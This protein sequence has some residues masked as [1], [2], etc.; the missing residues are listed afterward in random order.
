MRQSSGGCPCVCGSRLTTTC[1]QPPA[2]QLP[3]ARVLCRQVGASWRAVSLGGAGG[4][5]PLPVG[6]AAE[7][8]DQQVESDEVLAQL[9][10][11]VEEGVPAARQRWR[12]ACYQAARLAAE[13]GAAGGA[14]GRG[15]DGLCTH[16]LHVVRLA[17]SSRC[18]RTQ[19]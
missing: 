11:E 15:A 8:Q 10:W 3:R 13:E 16:V 5:G 7:E 4:W 14:C 2:G 6:T 19:C 18:V 1:C 9:G 12:W 17:T